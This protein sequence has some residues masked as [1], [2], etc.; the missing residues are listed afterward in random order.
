MADRKPSFYFTTLIVGAMLL[1]SAQSQA[2]WSKLNTFP[3]YISSVF[4]LDQQGSATTGF[5]GLENS[6]IFRTTDNGVTWSQASTPQSSSQLVITEFAFRNT[7]Q[8]W[9]SYEDYYNGT[10][11]GIWETTD[12]G[13]TWTS[14]YTLTGSVVS[15][16]FCSAT[17]EL[18]APCWNIRSIC[19]SD[20][21]NTWTQ[22]APEQMN[23]VTFSG[24]IGFIG[25]Y[26]TILSMLYSTDGGMSW[27]DAATL[28]SETW[29]PCGIPGTSTFLATAEKTKRFYISTNGGVN[30]T[31]PYQ[32]T[33]DPTGCVTGTA[34]NFFVQTTGDGFYTS[35]DQGNTWVSICGPS[36]YRDTRFYSVGTQIFAGDGNSRGNLWY[37]E[38]AVPGTT[39]HLDKTTIDFAGTQCFT[40]D[41]VLHIT[42]SSPC[43]NGTLT[44]AQI[45]SGAP[46]FSLEGM[47]LPYS[48][49]GNDSLFVEYSPSS[50]LKD[51][52]K[53]LLEF[54][55]GT[56]TVDTI[57]SL[58]GTA[59]SAGANFSIEP[60]LVLSAPYACV[61][62]DSVIVIRNLA[63]DSL[64]LTGVS[65]SD[66][67]N[68]QIPPVPLPYVMGPTETD[69][70]PIRV[71]RATGGHVPFEA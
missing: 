60:S 54:N 41:S 38:N 40:I 3:S 11:G 29:S 68:F 45:L 7:M 46:A 18:V 36:N 4:F 51:S 44:N 63:C 61:T 39:L 52:G 22:F 34:N 50:S 58:Y 69:T 6:A 65:L 32:F 17:N 12:G 59:H 35:T 30:W 25:V 13:Q 70:I 5:V 27:N 14:I 23:G 31:N 20:L 10:N 24:S 1:A 57:I 26:S 55:V 9:C 43:S 66:N 2:Q 16:G 19:S 33:P 64:M 8:G 71:I 21:G 28:D 67:A 37:I 48:L 15:I 42:S 56:Q 49:T 53:L 62:K 47:S